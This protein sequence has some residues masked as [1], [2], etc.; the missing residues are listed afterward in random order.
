M[1]SSPDARHVNAHDW[2][3]KNACN[4]RVQKNPSHIV[5]AARDERFER[6]T[7]PTVA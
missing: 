6:V 4:N 7:G 2:D 1:G 3:V 5:L